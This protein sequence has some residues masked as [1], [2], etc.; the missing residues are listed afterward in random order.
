MPLEL[1]NEPA[2]LPL[3]RHYT[4]SRNISAIQV[5]A[6]SGQS[7]RLGLMTQLPAGAHLEQG[8]AGFDDHTILIR[9]QGASYYVFLED[10]EPQRKRAAAAAGY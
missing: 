7:S 10:L 2:A 6:G 8:G 4:L 3:E 5:L 1:L 9:C